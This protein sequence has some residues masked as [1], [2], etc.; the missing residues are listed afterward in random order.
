MTDT[1]ASENGTVDDEA[2]GSNEQGEENV[3]THGSGVGHWAT[4]WI[5]DRS[6]GELQFS[7]GHLDGA[8]VSIL[9]PVAD[10]EGTGEES[11]AQT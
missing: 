6:G 7:D 1:T 3:L 11:T 4:Q 9:L 10:T 5:V 8:E 2:G